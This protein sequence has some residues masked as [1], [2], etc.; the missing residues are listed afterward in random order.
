MKTQ[1]VHKELINAWADGA[2]IEKL[3][4][5]VWLAVRVPLWN[6]RTTYRIK[7]EPKPD[8]LAIYTIKSFYD[9]YQSDQPDLLITFDGETGEYKSTEA[10]WLI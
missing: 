4:E 8:V 1:H 3:K 5:N 6:P 9:G 10:M 2:E 7:P